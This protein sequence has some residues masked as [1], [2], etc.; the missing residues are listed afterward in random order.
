M[1]DL[2]E[3]PGKPSKIDQNAFEKLEAGGNVTIGDILQLVVRI[4]LPWS[5]SGLTKENKDKRF[6]E[7]LL[8][9]SFWLSEELSGEKIELRLQ[10]MYDCDSENAEN[11]E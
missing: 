2:N 5:Q 7:T 10:D 3:D 9:R 4:G 11:N 1:S 6:R 8:A